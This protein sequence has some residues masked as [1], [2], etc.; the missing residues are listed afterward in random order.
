MIT[1]AIIEDD[2]MVR[3]IN[4]RYLEKDG[5]FDEIH[6]FPNGVEA[7]AF[8]ASNETSLVLLDVYMPKQNGFEFLKTLRNK[9]I[10]SAVRF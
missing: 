9:N 10:S 6:T 2:P 4:K 3:E 8:L 5:R 7:L 1:A